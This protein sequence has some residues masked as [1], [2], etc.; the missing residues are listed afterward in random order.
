MNEWMGGWIKKEA[1]LTYS[2]LNRD[3][4]IVSD[5]VLPKEVKLH[6]VLLAIQLWVQIDV[7]HAKR[8]AAH[9][10]CGFSFLLLIACSQ[11]KLSREGRGRGKKDKHK[12]RKLNLI[13]LLGNPNQKPSN[14]PWEQSLS[15]QGLEILNS[16]LLL[17]PLWN[18]AWRLMGTLNC[19]INPR[20]SSFYLFR[21][22]CRK[23]RNLLLFFF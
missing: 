22:E 11:S 8:A 16:A 19:P 14:S 2:F 6:H 3:F 21:W 18:E 1:T 17:L 4:V 5:R 9:S 10:V 7:L 23:G 20:F 15:L 12:W 13:G